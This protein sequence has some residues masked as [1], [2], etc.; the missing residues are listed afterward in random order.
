MSSV[1][2][3]CRARF[4]AASTKFATIQRKRLAMDLLTAAAVDAVMRG[5]TPRIAR[6]DM[7]EWIRLNR[8]VHLLTYGQPDPLD[9]EFATMTIYGRRVE[10]EE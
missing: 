5:E 8:E 2:D 7:N 6:A 1:Y 9:G 4:E 3:I 10:I